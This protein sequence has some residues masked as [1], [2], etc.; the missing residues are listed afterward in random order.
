MKV[1][2]FNGVGLAPEDR[3]KFVDSLATTCG[4]GAANAETEFILTSNRTIALTLNFAGQGFQLCYKFN[5]QDYVLFPQ[6][7]L[8][9]IGAVSLSP[10]EVL[11]S[12]LKKAL[13][14]ISS[15]VG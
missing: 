4:Q 8:N 3:V 13:N 11:Y 5:S 12:R 10:F 15:S 14:I 9:V 1:I 7:V 2:S 6:H